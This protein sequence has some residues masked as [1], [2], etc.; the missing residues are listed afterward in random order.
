MMYL[1]HCFCFYFINF[2]IA[3][4]NIFWKKSTLTHTC[5]VFLNFLTN[6]FAQFLFPTLYFFILFEYVYKLYS[7]SFFFENEFFIVNSFRFWQKIFLFTLTW[8]LTGIQNNWLLIWSSHQRGINFMV[9][10]SSPV[11]SLCAKKPTRLLFG[12]L[13]KYVFK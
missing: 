10:S 8:W 2:P 11:C 13:F 6:F 9:G 7:F 12:C 1:R 4:S 3:H 5:T